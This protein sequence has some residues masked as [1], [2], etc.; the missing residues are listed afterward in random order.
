VA[1]KV[2]GERAAGVISRQW[3]AVGVK[4]DVRVFPDAELIEALGRERWDVFLAGCPDP[5]VHSFFIQSIFLYSRSP[6]RVAADPAYDAML[7]GMV[8]TL[9]DGA[10]RRLAEAVDAHIHEQALL[11][12]LYQRIKTYGVRQG[13]T[14]VP[15]LTGMP[16]FFRSAKS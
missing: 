5:M 10:R 4:A 15:S 3:A 8:G 1:V 9:E 7:E 12:F 13:V 2:Q 11:L 16:H 14:F 6:Y